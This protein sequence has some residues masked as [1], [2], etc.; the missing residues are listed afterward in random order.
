MPNFLRKL[1]LMI[2]W[3]VLYIIQKKILKNSIGLISQLTGVSDIAYIT[4]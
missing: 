4:D 2:S 1:P 3:F